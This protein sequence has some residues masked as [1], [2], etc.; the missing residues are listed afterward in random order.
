M[1]FGE[2]SSED[3][4]QC[5]AGRAIHLCLGI[6]SA[7]DNERTPSHRSSLAADVLAEPDANDVCMWLFE[8][9]GIDGG[10][11]VKSIRLV[12]F[13]VARPVASTSRARPT[14][15]KAAIRYR[16]VRARVLRRGLLKRP[17]MENKGCSHVKDLG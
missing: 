3:A 12:F 13:L 4:T 11:L 7:V 6:L 2:F 15:R 10:D 5:G 16:M 14:R 9:P 8:N 17:F 1:M